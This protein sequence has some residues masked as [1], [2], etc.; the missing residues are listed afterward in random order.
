[1]NKICCLT[2]CDDDGLA[3][4]RV[5]SGELSKPEIMRS[6]KD[7]ELPPN[8]SM[9]LQEGTPPDYLSTELGLPIMSERFV[10]AIQPYHDGLQFISVN[11]IGPQGA[12][13][14]FL[15]NCKNL[16]DCLDH[17]KSE[18]TYFKSGH[19]MA[20]KKKCFDHSRIPED[21]HI[22]SIPE[23]LAIFFTEEAAISLIGKG[24]LGVAFVN[25]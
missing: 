12:P 19:L 1:M 8:F 20:I 14:Y 17:E 2:F 11:V 4:A 21:V 7:L 3:V 18:F 6:T 24:L 5:Q 25:M 13:R 10:S 22:F 23:L 15:M 9:V 16:V